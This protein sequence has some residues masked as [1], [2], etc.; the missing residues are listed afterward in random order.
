MD[1]CL[2]PEGIDLPDLAAARSQALEAAYSILAADIAEGKV[3]LSQRIDVEDEAGTIVHSVHFRD[4]VT[5]TG[6]VAS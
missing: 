5:I 3:N 2:D 6:Q 4:I 1:E